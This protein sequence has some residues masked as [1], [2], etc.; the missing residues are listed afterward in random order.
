[1]SF[2]LGFGVYSFGFVLSRF[3]FSVLGLRVWGFRLGFFVSGFGCL[4]AVAYF[5]VLA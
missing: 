5:F 4:F 2:L 1:M 3:E